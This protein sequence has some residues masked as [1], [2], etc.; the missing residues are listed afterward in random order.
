MNKI[1][2]ILSIALLIP[3]TLS[4]QSEINGKLNSTVE[5]TFTVKADGTDTQYKLKILE[6]RKYPMVWEK[7]DKGDVDQDRKTTAAK[8]T[9]LIA[10]DTDSDNEY[11][12]YFVLR[13]RKSLTDT[14]E[15]VPTQ[16][17]FAV[18]VDGSIKKH[19]DRE[20]IYFINNDDQDF[21]SVTDFR[22]MG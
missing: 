16:S 9:K 17:G 22:V 15:V 3:M 18:M 11:E 14:F 10:V 8:V 5:K 1:L 6:A 13:Y 21:F 4:A 2:S 19:F 12:Q 7:E 20:G